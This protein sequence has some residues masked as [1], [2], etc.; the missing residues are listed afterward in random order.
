MLSG[1]GGKFP[2]DLPPTSYLWAFWLSSFGALSA[3][4]VRLKSSQVP[5]FS[6]LALTS[7]TVI[8]SFLGLI[9]MYI[10]VWQHLDGEIIA[11]SIAINSHF[12]TR[13]LFLL[14]KRW[15]GEDE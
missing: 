2:P 14:R 4:L 12:S 13:A 8:A 9:T 11:V 6:I 15:L 3:Y 7:E 5:K 10:G 1:D